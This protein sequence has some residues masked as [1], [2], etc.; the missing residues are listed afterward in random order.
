MKKKSSRVK[1]I[2]VDPQ[3][4][5]YRDLFRGIKAPAS[6]LYKIEGI[7]EDFLPDVANLKLLDDVV[8]V[9]DRDAYLMAR[10][11]ATEEGLLAGSSS[12]AAVVGAIAVA[13]NLSKKDV[14]VTLLPDRGERYLSKLYSD[15]WMKEQGFN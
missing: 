3:G 6:K 4:S 11:L 14:V 7:G 9:S 2:G 8:T 12:G 1:V 10:R 13:K 5:A 15:D